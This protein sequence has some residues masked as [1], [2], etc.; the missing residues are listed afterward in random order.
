MAKKP[1][2][3]HSGPSEAEL[4][5]RECALS[6]AGTVLSAAQIVATYGVET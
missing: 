1:R 3:M 6:G 5:E 2:G 4:D